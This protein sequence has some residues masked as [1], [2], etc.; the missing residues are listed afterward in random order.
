M[1]DHIIEKD[2]VLGWLLWGI[3]K[4]PVLS[5]SW[6]LKGGLALKK[7]YADTRHHSQNMDFTGLQGGPW[8]PEELLRHPLVVTSPGHTP[9]LKTLVSKPLKSIQKVKEVQYNAK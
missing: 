3:A 8:E 2:Y 5:E 1:Q 6:I 7:C 4:H 9:S